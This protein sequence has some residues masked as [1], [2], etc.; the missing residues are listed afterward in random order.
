MKPNFFKAVITLLFI[1]FLFQACEEGDLPAPDNTQNDRELWNYAFSKVSYHSL[2]N[3]PPAI[4]SG[5]IYVIADVENGGDIIKLDPQGKEVWLKHEN[6][7]PLSRIIY[8]SLKLFYINDQKLVCRD[9]DNGEKIW[10]AEVPGAGE[11]FALKDD[12]IYITKFVDEGILGKNY[13][14]SYNINGDKLWETRLKYSDTDT[15]SFP[16]AISVNGNNIY[17][18]IMADE[19]SSEFAI[20]N[21]VDEGNSVSRNWAWLAPAGFT[22]G[23]GS[24]RIKEFAIDKYDNLL[25]GMENNSDYYV[26]SVSASG[27]ENRHTLT[28]LS[29][30]ISNVTVDGSGNCYVAYDHCEK[31]NENGIVW[32]SKTVKPDWQYTGLFSKAPVIDDDGNLYYLDLS[33]MLTSVSSQGDSLWS[34]YY[35]CNLCNNEFHNFTISD[36]GCIVVVS[37]AGVTAYKGNNGAPILKTGWPKMYGN[38][39]NTASK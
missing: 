34:Q 33:T 19:G 20:L 28:G 21:F 26:F 32:S 1:T 23:G 2:Y 38:L 4:Y 7:Y 10:E 11:L 9:A 12:K 30:T 6:H 35:G 15:V 17:V 5:F 36:R 22:V 29:K 8:S 39:T 27:S 24:P 14:V 16:N 18:G 3:Q 25:F 13:L 37:K 31:I